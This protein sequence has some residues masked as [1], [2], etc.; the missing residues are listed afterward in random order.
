MQ[1]SFAQRL[2][3][4]C[5]RFSKS[6]VGILRRQTVSPQSAF[7]EPEQVDEDRL[8]DLRAKQHFDVRGASF[9]LSK[10]GQMLPSKERESERPNTLVETFSS[11]PNSNRVAWL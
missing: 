1:L 7:R 2:R 4:L 9:T 6:P 10:K 8:R 3:Y 11:S 5:Q